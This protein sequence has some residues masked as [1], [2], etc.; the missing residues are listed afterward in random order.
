MLRQS[1][2]TRQLLPDAQG[3]HSAPPQSISVS[4]PSLTLLK[5]LL[6]VGDFEGALVG[7]D[8]GV[9]VGKPVGLGVGNPV[10]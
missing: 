8:V 6:V 10:G 5:Q 1:E 9:V 7:R 4:S 2:S 3:G